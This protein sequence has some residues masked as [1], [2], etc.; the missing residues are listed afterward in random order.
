[1][2][3][4]LN[5]RTLRRLIATTR[6]RHDLWDSTLSGFGA[7]LSPGGHCAFVVRYRVNGRLRRF[8]IGPFPRVR[9]TTRCLKP[10]SHPRRNERE[11]INDR[12]AHTVGGRGLTTD[13]TARAFP[14]S[15]G[16]ASEPK[17]RSQRPSCPSG[18]RTRGAAASILEVIQLITKKLCG[19]RHATTWSGRACAW[20]RSGS[21]ASWPADA[22]GCRSARVL[23]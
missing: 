3:H 10:R 5:D 18:A 11:A 14:S 8:T 12:R 19:Q 17:R 15:D 7:R 20:R 9:A 4:P 6:H 22:R 1:M 2:A 16:A 13:E 23:A 21:G